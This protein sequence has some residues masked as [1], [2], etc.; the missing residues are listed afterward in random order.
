MTSNDSR[1][2]ESQAQQVEDGIVV[3]SSAAASSQTHR[4]LVVDQIGR[5]AELFARSPYLH[6]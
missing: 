2:V 3:E 1:A 5:Q 6:S 4:S